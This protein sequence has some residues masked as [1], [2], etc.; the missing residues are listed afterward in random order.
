M[1][2][3]WIFGTWEDSTHVS[4]KHQLLQMSLCP[5]HIH[6]AV[7]SVL[8]LKTHPFEMY[9]DFTHIGE[10]EVF[11]QQIPSTSRSGFFFFFLIVFWVFPEQGSNPS[12][13][14]GRWILKHWMTRAVPGHAFLLFCS[15]G[16][17]FFPCPE[18]EFWFP[19]AQWEPSDM[20][21]LMKPCNHLGQLLPFYRQD[22]WVRSYF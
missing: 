6:P 14:S 16:S 15:L 18:K 7:G 3:F 2:L 19:Q 20:C 12:P 22:N 5:H 17:F 4:T 11:T 10:V 9:T 1:A 21:S 13:L 8:F